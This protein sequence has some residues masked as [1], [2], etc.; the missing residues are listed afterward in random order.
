VGGLQAS[1]QKA[2]FTIN[3]ARFF[4]NL[5]FKNWA[6]VITDAWGALSTQLPSLDNNELWTWILERFGIR[7]TDHGA[8]FASLSFRDSTI[9][10]LGNAR[11]ILGAASD[12]LALGYS[13]IDLFTNPDE[14]AQMSDLLTIAAVVTS[15]IARDLIKANGDRANLNSRLASGLSL[16]LTVGSFVYATQ[17]A[18]SS[19]GSSGSGDDRDNRDRSNGGGGGFPPLSLL[20]ALLAPSF[21]IPNNGE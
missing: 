11:N 3:L 21:L 7:T 14:N 20:P 8:L 12:I 19:S 2:K 15:K 17:T 18:Q 4:I 13:A 1:I 5:G 16:I 6:G 10:G 9:G